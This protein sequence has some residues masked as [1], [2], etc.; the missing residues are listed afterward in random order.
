M[1]ICNWRIKVWSSVVGKGKCGHL[2]E[3]ERHDQG[4]P[5]VVGVPPGVGEAGAPGLLA[6]V[7]DALAALGATGCAQRFQSYSLTGGLVL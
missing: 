6:G 1:V 4:A 5:A 7:E 3:G 2:P